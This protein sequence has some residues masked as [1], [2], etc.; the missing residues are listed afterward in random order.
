MRSVNKVMLIGR[1]GKDPDLRYTQQ[2]Q[3]VAGF[4]LAT[5]ETWTDKGGEKQERTEWHNIVA[6]AKLAELCGQYLKKGRLVYVE[7]KIQTRKW[8]DKEGAARYTTEIVISDMAMLESKAA[9]PST[10]AAQPPDNSRPKPP[11][12]VEA[13]LDDV[14]F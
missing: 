2:G 11:G 13:S 8:E 5:S 14:P 12:F 4:S 9:S 6:W 7:G 10:E 3:A 1:L